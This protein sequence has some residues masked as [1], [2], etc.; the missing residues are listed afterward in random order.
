MSAAKPRILVMAPRS[1]YINPSEEEFLSALARV[2]DVFFYGPGYLP[3]E[4]LEADA[5]AVYEAH[6]PFDAALLHQ[7]F[8]LDSMSEAARS[9]AFPFDVRRFR[10]ALPGFPLNFERLPCVR[11]TAFQRMDYYAI[12]PEM[13]DVMEAFP[14]YFLTWPAEFVPSVRVLEDLEREAWVTPPTDN[15]HDFAVRN[16]RRL[17]PYMHTI[18]DDLFTTPAAG[19]RKWPVFVPG[20]LYA[21]RHD[22]LGRLRRSGYRVAAN[23]SRA[24]ALLSR[25]S[26]ALT[27]K[28]LFAH[29]AAI[30]YLQKTFRSKI[31]NS[32]VCYTDGSRLRWPIRKYF[33]IPAFGSLLVCDP[34][35]RAEDLGFEDGRN[36]IAASPDELPDIV[37]RAV[38]DPAWAL[39]T[40]TAL[41]EMV[42][43]CHAA[44]VRAAQF[45][46]ALAAVLSGT[47]RGARWEKGRLIVEQTTDG[48]PPSP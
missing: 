27:G 33:E 23:R 36:F 43:R 24:A 6:G 29:A 19:P 28:P 31:R 25:L 11:I 5:V 41:Q 8:L 21:A 20:Q 48:A 12:S 13:V 35:H 7:Y 26:A 44:S 39:K 45:L 1:R 22:A 10:K 16:R 37:R 17:I 40:I 18:A 38:A 47:F 42:R 2:A 4:D 14:G 3:V 9:C 30:D 32:L 15:Y 46:E 34:F